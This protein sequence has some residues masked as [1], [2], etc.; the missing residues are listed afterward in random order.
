MNQIYYKG[1]IYGGVGEDVTNKQYS[2][3]TIHNPITNEDETFNPVG[4]QNAEIFNSYSGNSRNIAT[5]QYSQIKG[6]GNKDL[7]RNVQGSFNDIQGSNN[8]DIY[9]S[10]LQ[11]NGSNNFI[12]GSTF[13]N[14]N[15]NLNK[16]K[17]VVYS[18]V[19]GTENIIKDSNFI[20]SN[21]NKN[22]INNISNGLI[23]GNQN[24]VNNCPNID[25]FIDLDT[26]LSPITITGHYTDDGS[27]YFYDSNDQKWTVGD[28]FDKENHT[29]TNGCYSINQDFVYLNDFR[30][31]TVY[32]DVIKNSLFEPDGHNIYIFGDSND[33]L[34][35]KDYG[36]GHKFIFGESNEMSSNTHWILTGGQYNIITGNVEDCIIYGR[37]NKVYGTSWI[38][39]GAVFGMSNDIQSSNGGFIVGGQSNKIKGQDYC[40]AV[41]GASN[42]LNNNNAGCLLVA[43]NGN[44]VED[45]YMGIVVG[46]DNKV[47]HGQSP[48]VFGQWNTVGKYPS[49]EDAGGVAS[50]GMISGAGN[51]VTYIDYGVHV[52]GKNNYVDR[53]WNGA[54]ICGDQNNVQQANQ[55]FISGSGNVVY[56]YNQSF[57][58]GSGNTVNS[59]WVTVTAGTRNKIKDSSLSFVNGSDNV[60]GKVYNSM[61]Q[62]VQISVPEPGEGQSWN[63]IVDSLIVGR[64]HKIIGGPSNST[65]LGYKHTLQTPLQYGT[66]LGC[67]NTIINNKYSFITGYH[68]N[69]I[70]TNGNKTFNVIGNSNSLTS[71]D[72]T[73]V[74]G[75]NN[76]ITGGNDNITMVG[77]TNEAQGGNSNAYVFGTGLFVPGG[78]ANITI[79]G[80]Y[81]LKNNISYGTNTSFLIANG[82]DD[83]N[84][85]DAYEIKKDGTQ[86][87]YFKDKNV[88]NTLGI[89]KITLQQDLITIESLKAN[90]N[91]EKETVTFTFEELKQ[92][93]NNS[94]LPNLNNNSYPINS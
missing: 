60:L 56:S 83:N 12:D 58:T 84:R 30:K 42:S 7:T 94:Q 51:R 75:S 66:V 26:E 80:N 74:L 28:S 64:E 37:Y 39:C 59:G 4:G 25:T 32:E 29:F 88:S 8:I 38:N 40:S 20:D 62:G 76:T 11:G 67:E 21:G 55:S 61:I 71:G 36:N 34:G 17:N 68:N 54:F 43:G 91:N 47:Y 73:A 63:T 33:V 45:S 23:Y 49:G 15:G 77:N 3:V 57:I 41:F 24:N 78:C 1:D 44:I 6:V 18:Y 22:N 9:S 31:Y 10:Y 48:I 79:L 93:K 72:N 92:L 5:T 14:F 2:E 52:L 70:G 69:L 85:S 27:S 89:G 50:G 53:A 90:S 82:T 86:I 46:M 65:I 13:I 35:N 81:N 16:I 87:F 19:N